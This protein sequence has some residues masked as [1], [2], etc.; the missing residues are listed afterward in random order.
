MNS[1]R[2]G[3]HSGGETR[4]AA[5]YS[6]HA[7][8][9]FPASVTS[10]AFSPAFT[11][12]VSAPAG[13][14][15]SSAQNNSAKSLRMQSPPFSPWTKFPPAA[16]AP[17]MEHIFATYIIKNAPP[18]GRRTRARNAEVKHTMDN[19]NNRMVAAGRLENAPMLSHEVMHEPFYAGTLLV[20][21]LSGRWTKSPSPSPANS[22]PRRATRR[23][24]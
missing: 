16:V 20:K 10:S 17:V 6:P 11:A 21:R 7:V 4:E 14:H 13:A 24:N 8:S 15:K 19:P 9:A 23:A 5:A 2:S 22:C 12:N 1:A 18:M 3:G